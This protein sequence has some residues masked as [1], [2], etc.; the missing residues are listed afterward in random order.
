[1]CTS[2][3]RHTRPSPSPTP[4]QDLHAFHLM[5]G[6]PLLPLG[7][8]QH[9]HAKA[10]VSFV[11]LLPHVSWLHRSVTC[12]SSKREEGVLDSDAEAEARRSSNRSA[13]TSTENGSNRGAGEGASAAASDLLL[14]LSL[15]RPVGPTDRR[16]QLAKVCPYSQSAFEAA[17]QAA[18]ERPGEVLGP[19]SDQQLAYVAA[20]YASAQHPHPGLLQ[21][22]G[23]GIVDRMRARAQEASF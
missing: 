20:G 17:A 8:H 12:S 3:P 1:M 22:I 23:D 14:R 15:Y 6:R 11:S 2:T 16:W 13:S 21:A 4:M 19:L 5:L 18:A 9:P 10:P 7:G